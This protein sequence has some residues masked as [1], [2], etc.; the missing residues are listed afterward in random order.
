MVCCPKAYDVKPKMVIFKSIWTLL[1]RKKISYF[2]ELPIKYSRY[3]V[4]S[5]KASKMSI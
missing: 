5:S 3:T 2:T 1:A 4:I